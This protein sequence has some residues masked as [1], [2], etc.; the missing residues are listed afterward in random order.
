MKGSLAFLGIEITYNLQDANSFTESQSPPNLFTAEG[1]EPI[2]ISFLKYLFNS[3][4][5]QL[6]DQFIKNLIENIEKT[7]I[8][9]TDKAEDQ[10]KSTTL[11]RLKDKFTTSRD[12]NILCRLNYETVKYLIAINII[13]YLHATNN[14]IIELLKKLYTDSL[15]PDENKE[16]NKDGANGTE[17]KQPLQ[18]DGQLG[19]DAVAKGSASET[20]AQIVSRVQAPHGMSPRSS[21]IG[22]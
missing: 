22:R 9:A 21:L 8:S 20:D 13:Q 12:K 4:F 2:Y 7:C 11:A 5:I 16:L 6:K 14:S 17:V 18:E 1:Q 3:Q 10:A 15:N 19:A